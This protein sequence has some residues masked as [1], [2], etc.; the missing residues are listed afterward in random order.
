MKSIPFKNCAYVLLGFSALL[1]NSCAS[2]TVYSDV[3][4]GVNFNTYKSFA[5]LPKTHDADQKNSTFDNEII[6]NN[7]KNLTSGELKNRGFKVDINEPDLLLDFYISVANKVDHVTTPIYGHPYNYGFNQQTYNG[8][9]SNN[10]YSNNNSYYNNNSYLNMNTV[11][12]YSTQNIPYQEGTLT[13]LIIDRKENKLIWKGWS[14][15]TLYDEQSFEY[16]LPSDIRRLFKQFPIPVI[17][18]KK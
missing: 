13:I 17:P 1:F 2:T 5:W 15:G 11:V 14:V 12:G 7:I 16:E 9:Y 6:E 3:S 18:P 8:N 10:I 4:T